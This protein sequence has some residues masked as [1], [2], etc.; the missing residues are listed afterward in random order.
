MTKLYRVR[1]KKGDFEVEV[2]SSEQSYVDTKLREL[3]ET[4]FKK[5]T[6]DTGKRKQAAKPPRTSI[7]KA[8]GPNLGNH[9]E[10]SESTLAEIITGI[11]DV[12]NFKDIEKHVLDKRDRLPRIL[13]CYYFA[14]KHLKDPALTTTHV[15]RITEH[16]RVKIA[17]PNTAKVIREGASQYLTA[18]KVRKRGVAVNYKINRRGIDAFEKVV[19][20]EKL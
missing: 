8:I 10:V 18:D 7:R 9:D 3:L 11:N 2:E 16:F 14:H 1:Y 5:P 13:M 19:R 12:D 15:E 4:D 20:G 17:G 6:E